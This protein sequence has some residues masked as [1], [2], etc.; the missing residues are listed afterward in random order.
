MKKNIYPE[1]TIEIKIGLALVDEFQKHQ[2]EILSRIVLLRKNIIEENKL[3]LPKI[4]IMDDDKGN[5]ISIKKANC[6]KDRYE[7]N[8]DGKNDSR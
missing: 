8:A 7:Y 4:H 5:E 1:N 2:K 3:D 6:G